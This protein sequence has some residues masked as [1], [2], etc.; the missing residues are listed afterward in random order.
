MTGCGVCG[1]GSLCLCLYLVRNLRL[2]VKR[3]AK[4]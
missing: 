1:Q 3:V 4:C 2:D